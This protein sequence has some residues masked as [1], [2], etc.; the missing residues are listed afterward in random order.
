MAKLGS[1]AQE[2]EQALRTRTIH[3]VVACVQLLPFLPPAGPSPDLATRPVPALP[4]GGQ[5]A[6]CGPEV[7]MWAQVPHQVGGLWALGPEQRSCMLAGHRLKARGETSQGLVG[8][9]SGSRGILAA[10]F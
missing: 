9:K 6:S 2:L 8:G 4:L 7:A 5:G 1:C 10:W 3:V